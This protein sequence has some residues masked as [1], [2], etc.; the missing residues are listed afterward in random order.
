MERVIRRRRETPEIGWGTFSVLDTGGAR[1]VLAHRCDWESSAVVAL[2]NFDAAPVQVQVDLGDVDGVAEV[3]D[4]LDG[5]IPVQ[6]LE[7]DVLDL[8][9]EG[10]GHRWFRLRG[11]GTKSPP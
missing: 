1:S 8:A 5:S 3:V 4:L 11:P 6:P 10:Y 7:G 9:L 2:H